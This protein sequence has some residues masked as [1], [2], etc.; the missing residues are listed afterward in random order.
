MLAALLTTFHVCF[1]VPSLLLALPL[2]MVSAMMLGANAPW[3][4]LLVQIVPLALLAYGL[5]RGFLMRAG[6]GA[7]ISWRWQRDAGSSSGMPDPR[8]VLDYAQALVAVL[9][10]GA[11]YARTRDPT[12]PWLLSPNYGP[13]SAVA[14]TTAVSA[15]C[16]LAS[17][18]WIPD[19]YSPSD[20]NATEQ[21]AARRRHVLA[22]EIWLSDFV[23]LFA[24]IDVSFI[25]P[26]GVNGRAA[27]A[28]FWC[29]LAGVAIVGRRLVAGL[30]SS[31]MAG[32]HIHSS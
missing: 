30:I 24:A 18:L 9:V 16:Y 32:R 23:L 12:D 4:S 22:R 6:F 17:T 27:D 19:Y 5:V 31:R 13:P 15:V 8:Q 28:A 14:L 2:L 11:V 7:L 10:F 25:V 20:E 1:R 3:W 21:K 26:S 29:S